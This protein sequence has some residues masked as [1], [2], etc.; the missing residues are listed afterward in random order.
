[1]KHD[2]QLYLVDSNEFS[3][4]QTLVLY[5]QYVLSVQ[6]AK[7]TAIKSP[8]SLYFEAN[9]D[10]NPE[11]ILRNANN[12]RIPPPHYFASIKRMPLFSFPQSWNEEDKRERIFHH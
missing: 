3:V 4:P 11:R 5:K 9:R 6:S 2:L 1:L 12:L 7:C 8:V 10:A